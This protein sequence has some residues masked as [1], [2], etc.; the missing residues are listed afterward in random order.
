MTSDDEVA[1]ESPGDHNMLSSDIGDLAGTSNSK[2]EH[3][4]WLVILI[5]FIYAIPLIFPKKNLKQSHSRRIDSFTRNSISQLSTEISN[6]QSYNTDLRL[7]IRINNITETNKPIIT[8]PIQIIQYKDGRIIRKIDSGY[9][10]IYNYNSSTSKY[11]CYLKDTAF[12]YDSIRYSANIVRYTNVNTV[13]NVKWEFSSSEYLHFQLFFNIIFSTIHLLFVIFKFTV[14]FKTKIRTFEQNFAGLFSFALLIDNLCEIF[15]GFLF[16]DFSFIQEFS[17]AIIICIS[18][19]Y[20][21]LLIYFNTINP[22]PRIGFLTISLAILLL[23]FFIAAFDILYVR[24]EN[25]HYFL[26]PIEGA[27]SP[28]LKR[29]LNSICATYGVLLLL[30]VINAVYHYKEILNFNI[31]RISLINV[32]FFIVFWI[33][34]I[35]VEILESFKNFSHF[36]YYSLVSI[37]LVI[38]Y[39]FAALHAPDNHVEQ[40]PNF[41]ALAASIFDKKDTISLYV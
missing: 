14:D 34:E 21:I 29:V 37:N 28:L 12:N 39:N 9:L 40:N 17:E 22:K 25:T 26:W 24:L 31:F 6:L 23:V 15:F 32:P 18:A 27:N 16:P 35:F 10:P 38:I 41:Y 1:Y 13:I 30:V 7:Y 36:R 2:F 19:F 33:H 11:R 20:C 5:L 8:G 3:F 4:L